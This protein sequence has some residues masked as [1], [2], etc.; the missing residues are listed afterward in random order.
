MRRSRA[1]FILALLG[2]V[3]AA[4]G[5]LEL[6]VFAG[7]SIPTYEQTFSYDPGAFSFPTPLP[8]VSISQQGSFA[9][10]AKGGLA[11][12]ASLT[13]FAADVVGVEARVDSVGL[14]VDATGV[15]YNVTVS[16]SLLPIPP[17]TANLDLPPG[18]VDVD[19]LTPI[20]LGLKLRT[21]G[22][23]RLIFSAGG[24]YLPE[25]GA[26]ATQSLAIGLTR[27]IPPIDVAQ[28]SIRATARPG[29]GQGRWGVTGGVGFQVPLGTKASFQVEARGF[30]FQK[31]TLGWELVEPA[32]IPAVDELLKDAVARLDPV[33]FNPTFYQA[34]A[35]FAFRF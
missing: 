25:V 4:G 20:S 24:S 1:F 23:V 13:F 34:T 10:T 30:R 22:R 18:V 8:G 15:R 27:F 29:E 14:R 5:E 17:F 31:Q 2:P 19:R 12:G 32:A 21:S 7:P 33:E 35:G 16:N 9:L 3:G 6:G 28:A 26:T 11:A